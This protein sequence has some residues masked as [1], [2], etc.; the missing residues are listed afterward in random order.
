MRTRS[1]VRNELDDLR[2]AIAAFD[3]GDVE[4]SFGLNRMRSGLEETPVTGS[5]VD[6]S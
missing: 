2:T 3:G 1:E 4:P 6:A 5:L